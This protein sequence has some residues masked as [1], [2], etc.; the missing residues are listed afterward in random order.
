MRIF[1]GYCPG[2][3]SRHTLPLA[4]PVTHT[5]MIVGIEQKQQLKV[6]HNELEWIVG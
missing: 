2:N 3:L 6:Q 1:D 5:H 4:L